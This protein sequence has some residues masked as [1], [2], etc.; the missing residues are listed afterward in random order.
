ML[1][2]FKKVDAWEED[3][4]SFFLWPVMPAGPIKKNSS[5]TNC[6]YFLQYFSLLLFGLGF[7]G[8]LWTLAIVYCEKSYS[9]V[10]STPGSEMR[11]TFKLLE[12]CLMFVIITFALVGVLTIVALA[13][14]TCEA[15]HVEQLKETM[16]FCFFIKPL[17]HVVY[18]FSGLSFAI[19]MLTYF[20]GMILWTVYENSIAGDAGWSPF[21]LESNPTGSLSSIHEVIDDVVYNGTVA[22]VLGSAA[23]AMLRRNLKSL[24]LLTS[25]TKSVHVDLTFLA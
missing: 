10:Q 13:T 4:I 16:V 19:A 21:R 9:E 12:L 25:E 7:H 17:A 11:A 5:M 15:D 23:T 1:S 8:L 14:F 22:F 3:K 6:E 24:M 20:L 2:A 18:T